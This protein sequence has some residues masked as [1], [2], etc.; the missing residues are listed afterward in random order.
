MFRIVQNS[1]FGFGQF[2]VR[3]KIVAGVGISIKPR[4]I[5]ARNFHAK[6]VTSFEKIARH[7]EVHFV[8][9]GLSWLDQARR[10][11]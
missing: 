10:G 8:T 5:A 4:E 6:A 2:G 3:A 1:L 9:I 11:E 7:P